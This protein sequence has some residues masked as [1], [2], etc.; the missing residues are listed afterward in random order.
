MESY[1]TDKL[2][3]ICDMLDK[4]RKDWFGDFPTPA[5]LRFSCVD[6]EVST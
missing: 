4:N 6:I 2:H 3:F 5:F 1:L